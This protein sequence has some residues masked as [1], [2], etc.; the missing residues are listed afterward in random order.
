MCQLTTIAVHQAT[1]PPTNR[2]L[3]R[4]ENV[5]FAFEFRYPT[6]VILPLS[7]L[8]SG[9]EEGR[10][11]TTAIID[12]SDAGIG[13]LIQLMLDQRIPAI[14]IN[15]QLFANPFA[16][17]KSAGATQLG[18]LIIALSLPAEHRYTFRLVWQVSLAPEIPFSLPFHLG[19]EI[20]IKYWQ[21]DSSKQAI[22]SVTLFLVTYHPPSVPN[23]QGIDVR[24]QTDNLISLK[25]T[26]S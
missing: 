7:I 22:H 20:N 8:G 13:T 10:R 26:H 18:Y 17:Q 11:T 16:T 14:K 6:S 24:R 12:S 5:A 4:I 2:P 21:I 23:K 1:I 15:C 25:I 3:P 9:I 19:A